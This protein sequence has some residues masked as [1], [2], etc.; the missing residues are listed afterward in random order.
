MKWRDAGLL[1]PLDTSRITGWKDINPG[2]MK[3]KDLVTSGDGKAW[4]MPFD[5]GTS[6]LIYRTDK[7]T[8][9]DAKSLRIFADPKFQGRVTIGDNVD[10]AFALASLV[11]GLKDWTKM[12]DAQFKEAADFLRQVHKIVRFYWTDDT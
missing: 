12:T 3:M 4:L 8:P 5:W 6:S 2:L 9:E 11:I 1:Q 10:D 7:V